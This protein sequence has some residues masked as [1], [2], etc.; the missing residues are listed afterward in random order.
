VKASDERTAAFKASR[1]AS[2]SGRTYKG[3]FILHHYTSSLK[4]LH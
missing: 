2:E 4:R 3:G 1:S